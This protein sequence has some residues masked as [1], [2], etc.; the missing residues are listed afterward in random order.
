MCV[1]NTCM[2]STHVDSTCMDSMH[3]DSA[4]TPGADLHILTLLC[5]R[6]CPIKG[7]PCPFQ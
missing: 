3:V 7:A 1:E 2:D 4:C 6:A 5:A